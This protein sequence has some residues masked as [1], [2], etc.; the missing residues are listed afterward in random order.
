MTR[1][2]FKLQGSGKTTT[3]QSKKI[4]GVKVESKVYTYFPSAIDYWK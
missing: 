3:H 2:K 1:V 4:R